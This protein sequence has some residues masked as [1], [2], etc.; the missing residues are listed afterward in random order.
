MLRPAQSHIFQSNSLKMYTASTTTTATADH[1][2]A[3]LILCVFYYRIMSDPYANP[4]DI[5][6]D[7]FLEIILSPG[8][9][10]KMGFSMENGVQS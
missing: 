7:Q 2:F 6:P 4:S 5:F 9:D 10:T 8:L 1:C 3:L